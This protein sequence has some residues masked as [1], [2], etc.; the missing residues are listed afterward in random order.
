MLLKPMQ[1]KLFKQFCENV[2]LSYV[3]LLLYTE[4]SWLLKG[5]SLKKFMGLFDI[6]SDFLIDKPEMKHL[7][8]VDGKA[9]LSSF[10]D[11]FVKLNMLNKQH[12]SSNETCGCL[13]H[14]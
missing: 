7:F 13:F 12:Q 5:K 11:F 4:V 9:F 2:N 8:T 14:L 6:P 3:K 1:N 10:T